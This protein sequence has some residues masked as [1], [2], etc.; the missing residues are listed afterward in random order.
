M[1]ISQKIERSLVIA[2]ALLYAREGIPR[3]TESLVLP[4]PE[5]TG[6]GR[7]RISLWQGVFSLGFLCIAPWCTDGKKR[8]GSGI[9]NP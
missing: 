9:F 5:G 1:L 7:R 4:L 3:R 2:D 6:T 8:C